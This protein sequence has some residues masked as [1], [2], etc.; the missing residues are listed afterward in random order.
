M[1]LP[2]PRLTSGFRSHRS[3]HGLVVF[4]T[5]RGEMTA[6]NAHGK[7]V[8]QVGVRVNTLCV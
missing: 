7:A 4:L 3:A 6:V 2:L 1:F 5:S 8:W